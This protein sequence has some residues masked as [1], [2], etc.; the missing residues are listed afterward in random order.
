MGQQKVVLAY[1]GGLD[2]SVAIRWLEENFDAEVYALTL[3][4]GQ[5]KD[6]EEVRKKALSIGAKEALVFDAREEFLSDYVMGL[7]KGRID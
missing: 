3:D 7:V 5:G 1:S 4:L 2:T 6:V